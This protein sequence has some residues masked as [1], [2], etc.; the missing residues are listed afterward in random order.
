[1]EEQCIHTYSCR[2]EF[3]ELPATVIWDTLCHGECKLIYLGD[4]I[5][6]ISDDK[7]N[8]QKLNQKCASRFR[9]VY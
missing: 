7:L 1:M 9:A 2:I 5:G 8:F 6:H 3:S 4:T